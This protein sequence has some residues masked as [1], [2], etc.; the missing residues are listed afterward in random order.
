MRVAVLMSTYN[1]EKY[2]KKFYVTSN[3]PKKDISYLE[4][5]ENMDILYLMKMEKNQKIK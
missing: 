5:N 3:I 1:G 2:F 4:E